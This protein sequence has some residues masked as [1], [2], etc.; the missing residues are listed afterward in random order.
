[1][2]EALD[3]GEFWLPPQFLTDDDMFVE[4]KEIRRPNCS[5]G[6]EME[7]GFGFSPYGSSGF[8]S[9]L[10]SPVESVV[11]ST[12][13]ESDEDEFVS[14]LTQQMAGLT[15]NELGFGSETEKVREIY[16]NTESSG[17]VVLF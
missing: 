14:V 9:D 1:M 13:T 2:A 10:S 5:D 7:G 12:E 8:S 15:R 3:D 16:R 11:G 4:K 17:L 6:S